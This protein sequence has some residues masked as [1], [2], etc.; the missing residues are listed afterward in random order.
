MHFNNRGKSEWQVSDGALKATRIATTSLPGRKWRSIEI[1]AAQLAFFLSFSLFFFLFSLFH[2]TRE[3]AEGQPLQ[4]DLLL[5]GKPSDS[6]RSRV[7]S[8]LE[9]ILLFSCEFFE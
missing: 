7:D 5:K 4:E 9:D 2:E 3:A 6:M 8:S 1:S